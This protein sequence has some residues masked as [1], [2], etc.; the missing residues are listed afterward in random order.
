MA[1]FLKKGF[2]WLGERNSE[3]GNL[4]QERKLTK[5]ELAEYTQV[6][7]WCELV[8]Y[9]KRNSQW[10]S[11]WFMP[12]YLYAQDKALADGLTEKQAH[13]RATQKAVSYVAQ[14]AETTEKNVRDQLY[15]RKKELPPQK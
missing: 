5:S 7:A 8:F 13:T 1:D 2:D 3:L 15:I 10:Y 12:T 14:K 6:G 11:Q 4:A 9:A